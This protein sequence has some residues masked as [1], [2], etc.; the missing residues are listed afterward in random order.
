MG[1][2]RNYVILLATMAGEPE[3]EL[4]PPALA[5]F[6]LAEQVR[7]GAVQLALARAEALTIVKRKRPR[8]SPRSATGMATASPT[9]SSTSDSSIQA[10][11]L[12]NPCL[13]DRQD[14][15]WIDH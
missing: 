9:S 6:V 8:E 11:S 4:S 2:L 5:T 3:R 1:S 15:G 12:V 14:C 13:P 10:S 7:G